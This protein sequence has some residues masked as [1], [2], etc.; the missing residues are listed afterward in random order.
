MRYA[1][2]GLYKVMRIAQ[3]ID[4]L[5]VG[6]AEKLQITF[7]RAALS[8]GLETTLITFNAYP[9]KHYY[10]ELK[11]MGVRIIEIKGR[12]LFDP[13]LFIKLV[14]ILRTEKFDVLHTHLTY[15]I[16]LGGLAGWVT[17]TPVVA[18]IHNLHYAYSW[19]FL[20]STSLKYFTK[21]RIAVGWEVAKTHKAYN[22]QR[23][24]EVIQ[25]PVDLAQILLPEERIKIRA[26]ITPDAS[27]LLIISVGR[28]V[29]GKGYGDLLD[30]LNDLRHTHP[31][32]LLIIVGAGS[33]LESI[34]EKIKTLNLE[35]HVKLL[36]MRADVPALLVASDIYVSA[37][38]AE[39]L[40]I[41]ILEAM[42]AGLPVVSTGVGDIPL[43]VK[44]EFGICVPPHQPSQIANALRLLL[45]DP[46]RRKRLGSLA[47]EYVAEHHSIDKWLAD[48]MSVYNQV[49]SA[50]KNVKIK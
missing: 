2:I 31:N 15:S 25:N 50:P 32:L 37:S 45:E 23:H 12:N 13:F 11:S 27:R 33:Y 34:N 19:H 30:A 36:G 35:D 18:S 21:R 9:E 44:P 40:P 38:H 10:Q 16:I 20:E 24:I 8:S 42:S 6:G 28:L 4:S 22:N 41:S 47:R 29:V 17:G 26:E 3:L 5:N 39:G 43:I 1:E 49:I 46:D 7:M 14:E 48:L